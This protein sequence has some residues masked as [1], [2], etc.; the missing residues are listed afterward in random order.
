MKDDHELSE[1]EK[2]VKQL[3]EE[4]EGALR[5]S[6]S[7]SA[8]YARR[9]VYFKLDAEHR[10]VPC[11]LYEFNKQFQEP[12]EHRRVGRTALGPYVVSTVFLCIDHGY[13]KPQFFETRIYST[14]TGKD[15]FSAYQARYATWEEAVEGHAFA[16]ALVKTGILP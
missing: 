5:A 7:Y 2:K 4:I 10:V 8:P 11:T 1:E 13:K 14:K 15:I 16:V 9:P 12:E 3:H 6:L